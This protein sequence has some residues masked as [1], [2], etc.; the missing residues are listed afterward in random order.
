MT[1]PVFVKIVDGK[2]ASWNVCILCFNILVMLW[3]LSILMTT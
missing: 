3:Q 1:F 2:I